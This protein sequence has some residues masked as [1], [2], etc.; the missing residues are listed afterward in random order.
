M[1][2]YSNQQ[3]GR[4]SFVCLF[5]G[6]LIFTIFFSV[7]LPVNAFTVNYSYDQSGRLTDAIFNNDKKITY[8]GCCNESAKPLK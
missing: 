2:N 8:K 7:P 6:I 3:S 5:I 1:E 4:Q